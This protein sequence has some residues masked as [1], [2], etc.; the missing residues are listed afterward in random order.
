[1][2][3]KGSLVDAQMPVLA[4]Q[5]VELKA[6]GTVVPSDTGAGFHR[7]TLG[8]DEIKKPTNRVYR[9]DG[10]GL[11]DPLALAK[12]IALIGAN[13]QVSGVLVGDCTNF[14]VRHSGKIVVGV[15]DKGG[16]TGS[17]TFQV[18]VRDATLEEW[19]HPGMSTCP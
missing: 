10:D 3:S 11:G 17:V 4:G 1:M 12:N 2:A 16:D 5:V 13:D 15:N 9:I 7:V 14:T 8:E 19:L 6:E 18:H